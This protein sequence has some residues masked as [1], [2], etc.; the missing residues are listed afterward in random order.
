MP[1]GA[2]YQ[3]EGPIPP[4]PYFPGEN[5]QDSSA[6]D[7]SKPL[8][9]QLE[10]G[11][12]QSLTKRT[13]ALGDGRLIAGSLAAHQVVGGKPGLGLGGPKTTESTPAYSASLQAAGNY[14]LS[15]SFIGHGNAH[16][17]PLTNASLRFNQEIPRNGDQPRQ[18]RPSMFDEVRSPAQAGATAE[19]GRIDPS[20][21]SS[22]LPSTTA[23]RKGS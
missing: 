1:P 14:P 20:V 18:A 3:T 4:S 10:G 19:Y 2:S 5:G 9:A 16:L 17:S 15:S 21:G 8:P 12:R 11:L 13:L 7:R 23:N 22:L 6:L